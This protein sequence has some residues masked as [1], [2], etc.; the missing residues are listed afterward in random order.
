MFVLIK[1][2]ISTLFNHS[3]QLCLNPLRF[4][5]NYNH[6]SFKGSWEVDAHSTMGMQMVSGVDG[7]FSLVVLKICTIML[8]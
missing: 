6:S 4:C 1:C 3:C 7:S 2:H 5:G 8:S